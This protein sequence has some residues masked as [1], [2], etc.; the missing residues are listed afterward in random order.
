MT[1]YLYSI[2]I[3]FYNAMTGDLLVT[4]KWEDSFFHR[5][6]R[7]NSVTPELLKQMLEKMRANK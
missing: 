4:G 5:F 6:E 3:Y 7:G 2:N 1:T